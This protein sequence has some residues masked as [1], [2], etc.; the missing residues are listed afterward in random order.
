MT[1]AR[2]FHTAIYTAVAALSPSRFAAGQVTKEDQSVLQAATARRAAI[3]REVEGEATEL[4]VPAT[5]GSGRYSVAVD[6]YEPKAAASFE[7]DLAASADLVAAALDPSALAASGRERLRT[8]RIPLRATQAS[9]CDVAGY[10][11]VRLVVS[12]TVYR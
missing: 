12:A 5:A 2:D 11:R 9:E 4:E 7:S 3:V 6:V 10:G 8:Q 1:L